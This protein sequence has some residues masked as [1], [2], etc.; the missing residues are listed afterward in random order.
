MKYI[1]TEDCEKDSE[2]DVIIGS[3]ELEIRTIYLVC[4]RHKIIHFIR[5]RSSC[6][7]ED[8]SRI[9]SQLHIW[10]YVRMNKLVGDGYVVSI[11]TRMKQNRIDIKVSLLQNLSWK[12][13]IFFFLTKSHGNQKQIC[14]ESASN[15][16]HR[17]HNSQQKH[18]QD[19]VIFGTADHILRS[20]NDIRYLHKTSQLSVWHSKKQLP[21]QID[22]TTWRAD[23]SWVN[24]RKQALRYNP[25]ANYRILWIK[26]LLTSE[27]SFHIERN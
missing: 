13:C 23:F 17:I 27:K 6:Q 25:Y 15:K 7:D 21:A 18:S 26:M 19:F 8:L 4:T 20:S 9:W 5:Y 24:I 1:N 14:V 2:I 22:K 10:S 12:S 16:Y 11:R 3:K